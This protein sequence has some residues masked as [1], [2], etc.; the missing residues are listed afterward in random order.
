MTMKSCEK[1][2]I[3]NFVGFLPY[4]TAIGCRIFI[5]LVM[6]TT[7]ISIAVHPSRQHHR[8]AFAEVVPGGVVCSG[9]VPHRRPPSSNRRAADGWSLCSP[10]RNPFSTS[11]LGMVSSA[12]GAAEAASSSP[13][14]SLPTPG[15]SSPDSSAPQV[16]I[17]KMEAMQEAT[18]EL[19]DKKKKTIQDLRAEGGPLTF[20]TPIGA[21]NPF[22]IYYGCTS[23]FLGIPWFVA[24]K[25][26]QFLYW[27]SRG[28][29]DPKVSRSC[30]RVTATRGDQSMVP[31]ISGRS[32]IVLSHP[33]KPDY[34]F[35]RCCI[36]YF[37]RTLL[38]SPHMPSVVSPF[39]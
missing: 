27:I 1:R 38:A 7:A 3:L 34:A 33:T 5:V 15:S 28:K 6:A 32:L 30:H 17:V 12:A 14:G 22:A 16:E 26:C 37:L 24:C 13:Q 36:H 23:I 10:S 9:P 20:N 11:F 31:A 18:T 29:F 19:N 2:M 35:R 8:H 21:L 39:S 25:F 4:G